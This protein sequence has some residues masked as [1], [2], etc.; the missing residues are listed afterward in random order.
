[1]DFFSLQ[2]MTPLHVA[3]EKTGRSSI[4]KYL[5]DKGACIN[6]KD[7]SGVSTRD[8]T[9]DSRLVLLIPVSVSHFTKQKK[10]YCINY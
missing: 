7:D 5:V 8:Y 2:Q 10:G 1:M 4:V 9:T 3:T 6:I